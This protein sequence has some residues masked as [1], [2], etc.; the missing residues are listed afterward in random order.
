[1]SA[2]SQLEALSLKDSALPKVK[3]HAT[4]IFSILNHFIRRTPRE[5]RVMGTLLGEVKEDGTVEITD[6]FAVPFTEKV[7][8]TYVAIDQKYHTLMYA[9]HRRN[10]KKEKALGWYTST[11]Q[12]GQFII[13]TSSLIQDFYS[14]ECVNPVHLVVDT[15]LLGDNMGIRGFV[16]NQVVVGEEVLANAFQEVRV[17][18]VLYVLCSTCLCC[19][20]CMSVCYVCMCSVS[21]MCYI[22]RLLPT[23]YTIYY[24]LPMNRVSSTASR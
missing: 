3:V 13:D 16:S 18:Y 21:A 8:E 24:L 23:I 7:E 6:C 14:S 22:Y 2:P 9:F 12:S 10:N 19:V 5:G 20:L 15:T 1:M 4:A 11:S 17:C